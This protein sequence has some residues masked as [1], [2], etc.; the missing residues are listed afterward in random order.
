MTVQRPAAFPIRLFQTEPHECGYYDDRQARSLVLD[1]ASPWL[2]QIYPDAIDHGF[3]RS[4]SQVYRPHCENCN[5]CT[6]TR[7]RVAGFR[8]DRS[9]RRCRA[10]NADLRV[11]LVPARCTEESFALY[12][13][14][15]NARHADGPMARSSIEE[16]ERFLICTWCPTLFLELRLDEEL[17]GIAVT[18]VL[19]QGLSAVYTFFDPDLA[20]RGLGTFAILSQIEAAAER[21]L[22]FVYLGYWI[23]GHPKMDYK[24]R[25]AGLE[26]LREGCWQALV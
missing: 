23:D 9:Q 2:A 4:G 18:D 10:R 25:F 5:A 17:V 14:Y 16:F 1:P 13:R 20:Q 6:P 11:A 7:L 15:V 26:I 3:R 21:E 24:R 12:S 8:P 19:P 22:P